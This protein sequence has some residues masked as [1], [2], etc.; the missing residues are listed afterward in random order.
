MDIYVVQPG[1]TIDTIANKYGVTILKLILDNGL[2]NPYGLVPGQ[3]IVIT[4]PIQT[5]IVQEGDTLDSISR[6]YDITFMQLLRNNSFLSDREYIYPG[7]TLVISYDT[8]GKITTNG[9]VYPY[10]NSETLMKTLPYLTYLSIFNHWITEEGELLT[11]NDDIEIINIA[12]NYSVV[13]LMMLSSPSFIGDPTIEVIYKI[14]SNE[15][16]R[17][18]IIS[19]VL[20]ILKSSG[21]YGINILISGIDNSNQNAYIDLF[22]IVSNVLSNEGYQFFLTINPNIKTIDGSI[23]YERIDYSTISQ[24]VDGIMFL[25]YVWGTN[26]GPPSPVSSISELTDFIN[27]VVT[28]VPPD[29]LSV[30]E[31]IIG[32]DWE[33]PYIPGE[34]RAY[35][36][37]IDSAILL[38][39]EVGAIIEFD[40]TSQTPF[41]KYK[42]TY[43]NT[44]IEHIVWFIDAR[45]INALG[46]LAANLSLSGSGV[47]NIMTYFQQLWTIFNS[48]YEIVKII[49]DNLNNP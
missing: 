47:W 49:S 27:Y 2:K 11:S 42:V 26:L 24:L 28:L 38:A 3:S 32:Y 14:L 29:K 18:Q 48:Q 35:S 43:T 45:S 33:L 19:D 6:T 40:E 22:T 8:D 20:N 17:D 9:Y 39:H 36:L 23:S 34:S 25:Q 13:P 7:E 16:Y 10:I 1:D 4:Y 5:H 46:Q 41:F 44:P 15:E 21:Y 31:P 37:S 12:K 30:G